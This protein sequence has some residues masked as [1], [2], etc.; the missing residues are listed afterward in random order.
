MT[1]PKGGQFVLHARA[2]HGNPYDGHTLAAAVADVTVTT[3][4]EVKRTHVDRVLSGW[5][6]R[7]SPCRRYL[8]YA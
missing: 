1:K 2:L 4:V 6:I 3:G 5:F 8:F 7:L